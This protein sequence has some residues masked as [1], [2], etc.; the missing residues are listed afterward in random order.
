MRDTP[1]YARRVWDPVLRILH[2]WNALGI[3]IL[4]ALGGFLWAEDALGLSEAG[5]EGLVV[6]HGS[7]GFALAAGIMARILWL[8]VTGGSA[9][10][11]DILP[12]SPKQRATLV[13]TLRFY[14][15]GFQGEPPF[16]RAHNPLAGL[17]YAAFFVIAA[18]QVITGAVMF[19]A[20]QELAEA[21]E[22][23]HQIGFFLLIA[24]M[25]IHILMVFVHDAKEHHGLASAM[26]SGKKLFSERELQD[27]PESQVDEELE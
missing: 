17:A 20:E 14:L 5:E 25:V 9:S 7:V 2:W 27:H 13:A 15:R 21:W 23:V 1:L 22:E 26:I 16:Y 6:V 19:S 4:I 24:Y 12:I 18:V 3:G 10:W 11:R 8:F